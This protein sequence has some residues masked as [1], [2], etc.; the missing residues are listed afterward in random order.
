[1]VPAYQGPLRHEPLAVELHNTLYAS[2][3]TAIDGLAESR[4][5]EAWLETIADR[6]PA[7]GSGRG[8]ARDELIAL[9]RVVREAL[10]AAIED[11]TPS[12]ATLDALNRASGRAPRSLAARWSKH[13]P[14]IREE[15]FHGASRADI[16]ISV[17]AADA[18]DLVTG[19]N[20]S[21]LRV[22]GASGCVLMFL[23]SHPRREWCSP[24]CGNRARQARHYRRIREQQ[25]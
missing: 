15:R 8:P 23:K 14:P 16:V 19:T 21:L 2:H 9:R 5:A 12:R 22:C 25:A 4:S 3:G 10:H 18:I 7:G 6:L 24:G 11:G 17:L 13:G 20:R 1:M